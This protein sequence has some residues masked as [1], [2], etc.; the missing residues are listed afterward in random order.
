MKSDVVYYFKPLRNILND[1]L[2]DIYITTNEYDL[3]PDDVNTISSDFKRCVLHYLLYH[4]NE[5]IARHSYFY[6]YC[7]EDLND[8]YVPETFINKSRK[9]RKI[10]SDGIH[11]INALIDNKFILV[12]SCDI[13]V[14]HSMFGHEVDGAIEEQINIQ[15]YA[16]NRKKDIRKHI[17]KFCIKNKLFLMEKE[18]KV[19]NIV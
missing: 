4:F 6:L 1:A 17:S 2:V 3:L 12:D 14:P 9:I 8:L 13:K 15:H 7:N 19:H 11:R 18:F 5:D 10:I 16:K